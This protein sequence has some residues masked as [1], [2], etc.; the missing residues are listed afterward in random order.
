M[1]PTRHGVNSISIPANSGSA[2]PIIFAFQCSKFGIWFTFW[3]VIELTP[4]LPAPHTD[5]FPVIDSQSCR[6]WLFSFREQL[7]RLN[8][9][10]SISPS[11]LYSRPYIPAAPSCGTGLVNGSPGGLCPV[12]EEVVWGGFR[13]GGAS[14]LWPPGLPSALAAQP[15][16][17]LCK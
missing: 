17:L 12:S 16:S 6:Y 1:L 3:I 15:A 5:F 9:H 11:L 4:T 2:L 13:P 10:T 14:N 7:T 8:N